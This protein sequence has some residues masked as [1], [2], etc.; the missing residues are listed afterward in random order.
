M[1]MLIWVNA[2][3]GFIAGLALLALYLALE[4]LELPFAEPQRCGGRTLTRGRTVAAG[5]DSSHTT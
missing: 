4:L 5:C 1:I 2:H 3:P